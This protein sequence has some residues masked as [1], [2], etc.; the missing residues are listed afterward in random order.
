VTSHGIALN[1]NP[2]LTHYKDI[3]PCGLS[4]YGVTSVTDLGLNVS[5][6][7]VDLVLQKTFPFGSCS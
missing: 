3:V 5:L 1:V 2:D 6:K 7:E 4:Q